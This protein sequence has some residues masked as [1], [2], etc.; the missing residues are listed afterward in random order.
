MKKMYF[1]VSGLLLAASASAQAPSMQMQ[2]AMPLANQNNIRPA[3]SQDRAPGDVILTYEDDFSTPGNWN[4]ANTSSPLKN[5]TINTVGPASAPENITS[6]SGGNFAWYDCD[7][8]GDGSTVDATLTYGSTFNLTGFPAVM[9]S[10]EQFF[11]DYY[12]DTYV[13]VSTN[14]LAGPWTQYEVNADYT[15]NSYSSVNPVQT[16][17]NISAQAGGQSN[18]AVRFHY[19]GGW[20]WSWQ[21]D[22]FALVEAYQ[23]DLTIS[24][25]RFSTGTELNEYYM[26]PTAQVSPFTFGALIKSNGVTTQTNTYMHV[27]VDGGTEYD[28]V[29][30]QTISLTENQVDSFSIEGV[31]AWTPSG[32]GSYDLEMIAITDSYTDQ[33]ISDNTATHEPIVVGGNVYARDNGIVDGQWVG[34]S[35][36][37]GQ[38]LQVGNTFEFFAPAEF[39]KVQIG[40]SSA[41]AN[42]GLLCFASVYIWDSGL[43]DWAQVTSSADHNITA[44]E[45]GTIIELELTDNVDAA[46]GEVY[47]VC[48]GY[49]DGVTLGIAEAQVTHVG[50]V[51]AIS[52]GGT[53]WPGDPSAMIVRAVFEPTSVG[54]DELPIATVFTAYPNPANDQFTVQYNLINDGNVS[55][56][57]TDIA[58]KVVVNENYGNQTSGN[59]SKVL[60]ADGLS[61]GV[62]FYTLNV[63]GQ[64]ITRKLTVAKN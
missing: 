1:L 29:S 4:L 61:N 9:V 2:R 36:T 16:L 60:S 7:P 32:A 5:F 18:V 35:S 49:Y 51:S 47:L 37:N 34:F 3:E 23:H 39:G 26:I 41:A 52:A 59:Y 40:I 31:N 22:D 33:L 11:M 62:Y 30:G 20:G 8:Q 14:G 21:I 56:V 12:E 54:V 48:A 57:V 38:G 58:G 19:V 63:D 25:Q 13:E 64:S 28:E 46:A 10:F 24:N 44:S 42:E 45:L 17:V 55:L 27:L 15:P 43:S 50:S 6:T 53:M